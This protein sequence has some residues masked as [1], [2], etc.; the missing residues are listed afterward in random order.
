M[1]TLLGSLAGLLTLVNPCVLPVLLIVLASALKDDRRAGAARPSGS[2]CLGRLAWRNR[3]P[4]HKRQTWRG[5]RACL[6]RRKP[7]AGGFG[8]DSVCCAGFTPDPWACLRGPSAIHTRQTRL[9]ALADRAPPVLDSVMVLA[10]PA[11]WVQRH[12][13][14][15]AWLLS[16]LPPWLIYLYVSL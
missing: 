10:R 9:Q 11:P 6:D 2:V 14:A 1:D 12:H 4:L 7:V 3:K 16:V 8:D 15:G 5:H 13:I